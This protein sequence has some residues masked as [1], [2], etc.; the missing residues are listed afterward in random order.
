[1]ERDRP[2]FEWKEVTE[3]LQIM[4]ANSIQK[5]LLYLA[6]N[7]ILKFHDRGFMKGPNCK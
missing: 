5:V 7:E 2:F 4:L 3:T 1:M 6:L